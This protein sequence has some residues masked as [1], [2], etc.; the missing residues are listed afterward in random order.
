[1]YFTYRSPNVM[2]DTLTLLLRILGILG[3]NLVLETGCP[4]RFV[5]F[6]S[7]SIKIPEYDLKLGHDLFLITRL[8]FIRSCII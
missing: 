3:S 6:L 4:D 8:K 2:V 5:S 1:M 7:P